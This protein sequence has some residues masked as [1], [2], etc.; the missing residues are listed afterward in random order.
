MVEDQL[1]E[2]QIERIH[3]RGRMTPTALEHQLALV[4]CNTTDYDDTVGLELYQ[5][6]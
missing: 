2:Q 1:V 6:S 3:N 4:T 5:P